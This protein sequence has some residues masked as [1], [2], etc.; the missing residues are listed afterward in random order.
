ML[1]FKLPTDEVSCMR[2]GAASMSQ[3][4]AFNNSRDAVLLMPNCEAMALMRLF[5]S[6]CTPLWSRTCIAKDG[7][8]EDMHSTADNNLSRACRPMWS[9]N[10]TFRVMTTKIGGKETFLRSVNLTRWLGRE[11]CDSTSKHN[12]ECQHKPLPAND[13][14]LSALTHANRFSCDVDWTKHNQW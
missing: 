1:P 9:N 12:D 6:R 2:L 14:R 8:C 11:I 4:V 13:S 5:S 3:L 10:V 7:S